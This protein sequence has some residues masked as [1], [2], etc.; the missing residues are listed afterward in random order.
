MVLVVSSEMCGFDSFFRDLLFSNVRSVEDP[1]EDMARGPTLLEIEE[2][3]LMGAEDMDYYAKLELEER[4]LTQAEDIGAPDGPGLEDDPEVPEGDEGAELP[5]VGE[6]VPQVD[7]DAWTYADRNEKTG[8]QNRCAMIIALCQMERFAE[9][10]RVI[11][12]FSQHENM[13]RQLLYL[14]SAIQRFGDKGPRVLGYKW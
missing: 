5:A 11:T 8:W 12:L 4:I 9:L 7:P 14:K 13:W 1:P 2:G 3:V 6:G 10:D